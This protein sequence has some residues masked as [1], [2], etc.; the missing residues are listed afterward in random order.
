[1]SGT[2][3]YTNILV[4]GIAD[5]PVVS[6]DDYLFCFTGESEHDTREEM[7]TLAE[8]RGAKVVESVSPQL[9]YLVVSVNGNPCWAYANYG[10]KIE[11]AMELRRQGSRLLIVQESDFFDAM[12]K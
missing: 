3:L 4:S 11:K 6:F 9:N 12:A 8:D 1:L 7:K 5:S 10:R 2:S